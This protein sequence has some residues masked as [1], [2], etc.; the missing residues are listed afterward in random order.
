MGSTFSTG[1]QS[2]GYHHQTRHALLAL[3]RARR[4]DAV[5]YIEGLDG[6]VVETGESV[7]LDQLKHLVRREATLTDAN[8][9]LWKPLRV[10]AGAAGEADLSTRG[11]RHIRG[12][13]ER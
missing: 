5:I 9:D 8:S 2:L 10:W 12:G 13:F 1:P 6:V 11:T 4:E 3:L 7:G